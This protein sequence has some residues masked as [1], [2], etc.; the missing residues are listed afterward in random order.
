MKQNVLITGGSC[1]IGKALVAFYL[2][3][4]CN[5]VFN[6]SRDDAMALETKKEFTEVFNC[7][8]RLSM[9]KCDVSNSASV[10]DMFSLA[11]KTYGPVQILVNN[12][13]IAGNR[14]FT[15]ITDEEW[16]RMIDVD[17]SG[18]FYCSRE[19]AKSMIR[20]KYGRIVNISSMWGVT[21]AA[22]EVH[23]SAAKAGVIGLTKALA[24][25]LAPSG[26]TVNCVAPGAVDTRMNHCYTKEEISS[27]CEETPLGRLGTPMEIARAVG[28]LTDS[29][30]ITGQVLGVNGGMVI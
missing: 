15:D 2:D 19:A 16:K 11:E 28:F 4:G 24:K 3:R 1:G 9:V 29:D 20:S 5:V 12:A 17:L 23:Y 7:E 21:G 27:I 18:C 14:L 8:G 26:I 25:E 10:K 22:M 30:F 13:G 6:Y